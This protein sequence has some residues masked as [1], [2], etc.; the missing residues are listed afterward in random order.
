MDATGSGK[1]DRQVVCVVELRPANRPTHGG[2]AKSLPPCICPEDSG[3]LDKSPVLGVHDDG[4]NA[5]LCLKVAKIGFAAHDDVF[6]HAQ[7]LPLL[8]DGAGRRKPAEHVVEL[9]ALRAFS[10]RGVRSDAAEVRARRRSRQED[11]ALLV[12]VDLIDAV[13]EGVL[14]VLEDVSSLLEVRPSVR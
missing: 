5:H 8:E 6:V 1:L 14:L 13:P 3:S 7:D 4:W 2:L 12:G 9:L 11:C 10:P